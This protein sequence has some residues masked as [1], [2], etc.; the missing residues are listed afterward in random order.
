VRGP[1]DFHP[2]LILPMIASN[3]RIK[4]QLRAAATFAVLFALFGCRPVGFTP[5]RNP[6]VP[7]R[8]VCTTGIV[9]DLV[10]EVGGDRVR[11]DALMGPGVDP[12]LYKPTARDK[13]RINNADV[14]F[15]NGLHLEGRLAALLEKRGRILPVFAVTEALKARE[16]H[17]LIRAGEGQD[18]YDP[19][20]WFDPSLWTRCVEFVAEKLAEMDPEGAEYYRRNAEAYQ[21]RLQELE[22]YTRARLSEVPATQRM[23]VTAHDAF[24]YF[25]RAF[26]LEVRSLQGLSTQDEAALSR[27]NQ[28]VDLLVRRK[29]KAV[30]VESSVSPRNIQALVEGCRAQGHDL[31]IGGELFSDALGPSGTPEATLIGA[32]KANVETIVEGLR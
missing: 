4:T 24:A 8:V 21:A 16:A 14:V 25:G 17:R 5:T 19:H 12:H 9:A 18:A 13:W 28:L 1:R 32:F 15:Y 20:V 23:L 27:V 3:W 7:L 6:Q 26:D 10:R 2:T 29:I 31:R 22:A 30:F 11:L